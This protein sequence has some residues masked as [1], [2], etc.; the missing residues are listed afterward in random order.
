MSQV[1]EI[2]F[3]GAWL[4]GIKHNGQL[5]VPTPPVCVAIGIDPEPQRQRIRRDPVLSKGAIILMV[6]SSGGPQSMLCLPLH[7]L[8]YWLAGLSSGS[9]KDENMRARVVEYQEECADVLFA[10]FMPQLAQVLGIKLPTFEARL[11]QDDLLERDAKP[12]DSLATERIERVEQVA[13]EAWAVGHQAL[14]LA[15]GR[16][17]YPAGKSSEPHPGDWKTWRAIKKD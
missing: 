6:P 2:N 11:L 7:R 12:A 15:Q 14:K 1:H 10:Y 17:T 5:F 13:T 3:K 8:H 16:T 9:V 4:L